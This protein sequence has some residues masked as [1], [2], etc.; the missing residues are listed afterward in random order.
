MV[1]QVNAGGTGT[2]SNAP[3]TASS[4]VN[5]ALRIAELADEDPG[6]VWSPQINTR[7]NFTSGASKG[8]FVGAAALW[9]DEQ[10][11]ADTFSVATSTSPAVLTRAGYDI[12][13]Y[14][15]VNA[16]VGYNRRFGK[17]QWQAQL[18]INNLFDE[19]VRLGGYTN[20]RYNAPRQIVFTNT[21]T[22]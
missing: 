15:L 6:N 20:G 12:D 2:L 8:F 11:I 14:T 9:Y 16:F 4:Y 10:E 17:V 5:T 21:F 22:F 18:N 13:S 3:L 1:A 7:Y 19:Q